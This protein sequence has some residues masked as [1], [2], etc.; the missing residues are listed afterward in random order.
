[1]KTNRRRFSRK[2]LLLILAPYLFLWL[3][4]GLFVDKAVLNFWVAEQSILFSNALI[5]EC[6]SIFFTIFYSL[7]IFILYITGKPITIANVVISTTLQVF[8]AMCFLL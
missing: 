3:G 1:M 6:I 2:E 5:I 8:L 7:F 4:L